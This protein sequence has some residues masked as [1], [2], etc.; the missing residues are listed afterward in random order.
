MSE[1]TEMIDAEATGA[2]EPRLA[3]RRRGAEMPFEGQ[4]LNAQRAYEAARAMVP[5]A[6][7]TIE[8]YRRAYDATTRR[9]RAK[10]ND[11][12]WLRARAAELEAKQS[13]GAPRGGWH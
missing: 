11:P 9:R 6:T 1:M 4:Q 13:A 2:P 12:A 5:G 7:F 3:R 10:W 8:D